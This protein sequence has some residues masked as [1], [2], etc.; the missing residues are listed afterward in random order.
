MTAWLTASFYSGPHAGATAGVDSGEE[1]MRRTNK[2][3]LGAW[4][5]RGLLVYKGVDRLMRDTN[6]PRA[7]TTVAGRR[8]VP[9]LTTIG[10]AVLTRARGDTNV[11]RPFNVKCHPLGVGSGPV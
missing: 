8:D 5:R 2:S 11:P 7:H 1:L 4:R 6:R 9:I 10:D 3:K